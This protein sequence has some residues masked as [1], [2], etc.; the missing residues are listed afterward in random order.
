VAYNH[1]KAKEQ[2]NETRI[3]RCKDGI[4]RKFADGRPKARQTNITKRSQVFKNLAQGKEKQITNWRCGPQGDPAAGSSS[5]C[6]RLL[7]QQPV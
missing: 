1:N 7:N 4:A 6:V 5:V 3:T 2:P